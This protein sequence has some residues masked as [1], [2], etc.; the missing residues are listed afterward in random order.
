MKILKLN[1]LNELKENNMENEKTKKEIEKIKKMILEG[2]IIICG[3]DTLYGLC[4]NVL[5][6]NAVKKVYKL[7]KRD[8][9]KPISIFLKDKEDIEKYA[10][11]NE[12]S[13]KIIDKFL[14]GALTII[15]K[16]KDTI[17]NIVSK[18]YIGIRI[19]DSEIIREL[20]IVP[21]TATSANLSGEK[22]PTSVKEISDE[23][24]KN[25]DLIIDTGVCKYKTPSTIIKILNDNIELIREGA[26][27]FDKIKK[28]GNV[29]FLFICPITFKSTN[30]SFYFKTH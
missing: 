26:I 23:L 22:P 7:K 4:A 14:P 8:L 24:R 18:D 21:L 20:S 30:Q 13:K 29:I 28:L 19:P 17:P 1:E 27:P 5:D 2:K 3:T 15:L 9:N 12:I 11:V 25:V 6:E 10:Y 16:K